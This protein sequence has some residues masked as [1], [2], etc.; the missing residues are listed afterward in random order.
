M[1]FVELDAVRKT[2]ADLGRP[3]RGPL[4]VE[5]H[6]DAVERLRLWKAGGGAMAVI[7][8]FGAYLCMRIPSWV[9]V[10]EGEIPATLTYHAPHDAAA[11]PGRAGVRGGAKALAAKMRQPLGRKVVAALWGNGTIRILTG[12]LPLYIAFYAKSQQ[13]VHSDWKQL[14]TIGTDRVCKSIAHGLHL[15][16]LESQS[17][18]RQTQ[19]K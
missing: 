13:G 19:K 10:T 11:T 6:L 5:V 3:H 15:L 1:L 18:Q 8:A 2:E 12:F 16:E 4:D 7:A 9:E 14:A 17:V